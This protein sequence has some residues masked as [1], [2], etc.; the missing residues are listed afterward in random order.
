MNLVRL[1]VRRPVLTSVTV[2]IAVFVG[3][4]SY[5]S[6]GMTLTPEVDLPLVVVSTVYEG[7]SPTEIESLVT[8]PIEDASAQV[9]GIK[10]IESYSMESV[11]VVLVWFEYDVNTAD[12]TLAVSN[13]VKAMQG[14]LPEDA[15]DPIV[16]KYDINAEPFISIAVTSSLPPERI[17]DLVE[18]EIQRRLTQL[19]GLAKAEILGGRKREIHVY[20]DPPKLSQYGLSIADV[21]RVVSVNNLTDPSGHVARGGK[22]LSIRV[23]GEAKTPE[24]L[25]DIRIPL[26][27]GSSVRLGDLAKVE[28]TTEETR[29][30]GR[31]NDKSAVL[32]ECISSPNANIVKLGKRIRVL[33]DDIRQDLPPGVEVTITNDDSTFVEEA[34]SNVFG[35][36]A[37]GILFTAIALFLFLRRLSVTLVAAISMPTAVVATFT[38]MYMGK[39]TMNLMSTLG[40]AISIG[41]LVNNAILVLE[42]IYRYGEMGRPS[43][44]AAVEGTNEITLAVLSSTATNLGVF[45]PVAFMGGIAGQFLKDFALTVVFSTLFSLWVALTFTPM[46]AG[47]VRHTGNLS[48]VSRILTGWWRW[49]YEGL[50]ELH[51]RAVEK[52]LRHPWLTLLF[53]AAL[54]GGSVLLAPRIGVEFFPKADEGVVSISLELPSDASLAQT[55]AV[56]RQVEDYVKALPHVTDVDVL[57]GGMGTRSGVNYSRVRFFLDKD[58][59]RPSTFELADR[60]RPFLASLPDTTASVSAAASGGGGPGKAIQINIIGEDIAELNRLAG[61]VLDIMRDTPGTVDADTNWRLGRPELRFTPKRWRLGQTGLTVDDLASTVRAYVTGKKAGVFRSEGREYDILVKLEPRNVDNIF[62]IP[63]LPVTLKDG[64]TVPVRELADVSY[65]AGPTRIVRTDRRR[66]V[67]IQADAA[68]RTVGEVFQDIERR[69]GEVSL[70]RGYRFGLGG[71]VE[72]ME[73][74]F[75]YLYIAFGMAIVLTFLMIAAIIESYLFAL[76]I[77]LT[78]PLSVIGV[79]PL[80]FVTNTAVSIYGLLGMVMLVGLV[81]NNAIVIVDYAEMLRREQGWAPAEAILEATRIRFRPILMC[82]VTSV[83]AMI[84]LALGLGAGGPYRAPMAIVVIGGLIAGG[85][86]ALFVIPPVYDQVWRLKGRIA[87]LREKLREASPTSGA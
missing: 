61:Q 53:F 24:M 72:D 28:D 50:E 62:Q 19:E 15:K 26:K 64:S 34:V 55:E 39:M 84:P 52:C 66:A 76:L 57:V 42:N 22:E 12:A 8:K 48:W 1:F 86:L 67:T 69:L 81:V 38:L 78:V 29:G 56:T 11:S 7:A 14:S 46:M 77:M 74:N 44:D 51:H 17:Y 16:E 49:L 5:L 65:G 73:E 9:E 75:R 10:K 63:D 25:K 6:L 37:Q 71:E 85:T 23:L 40:L 47:R 87:R 18:E 27:D 70:P 32:V 36:M 59:N 3:A 68:G 41:M 31:Y 82:D 20:L 43:L 45:I 2:L 79:V 58:P 35:N 21:I 83:V 30:Y 60:I 80:L 54:F 4:Y 13:R 33:L